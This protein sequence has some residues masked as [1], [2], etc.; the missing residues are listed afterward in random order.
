[1]SAVGLCERQ[2]E[3]TTSHRGESI[4]L[5]R[6]QTS[7]HVRQKKAS[8]SDPGGASPVASSPPGSENWEITIS[9]CRCLQS[10]GPSTSDPQCPL[11]WQW[12]RC[13]RSFGSCRLG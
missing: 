6:A 11:S 8:E 7:P 4:T 1:M 9:G 10:Q 3:V 13:C 5:T 12:Q 2:G